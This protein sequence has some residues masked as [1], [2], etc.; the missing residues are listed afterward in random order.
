MYINL[1]SLTHSSQPTTLLLMLLI[2]VCSCF[3][4]YSN[5][6]FLKML[7]H[8]YSI[9][10]QREYYRVITSDLVHNDITHLLL[11]EIMIFTYCGRLE[12]F[13][14]KVRHR[15]SEKFLLIYFVS[16]LSGTIIVTLR[17]Y[18]DFGYS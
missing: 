13:L 17:N 9:I 7:L 2:F 4:L 8:P 3:S 1:S 18:K 15:G 14:N 5:R 6:F 11:N 16:C 12:Q 10:R